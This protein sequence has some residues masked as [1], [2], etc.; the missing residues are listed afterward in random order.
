MSGPNA[1]A[2]PATVSG[3]GLQNVTGHTPGKTQTIT[4]PARRPACET[5]QPSSGETSS[6]EKNYE[7]FNAKWMYR[8]GDINFSNGSNTTLLC[9]QGNQAA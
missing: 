6:G 2:A 4:P 8:R 7:Y 1:K 9:Y 3:S 5:I